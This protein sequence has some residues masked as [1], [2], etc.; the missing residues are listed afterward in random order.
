MIQKHAANPSLGHSVEIER[1]CSVVEFWSKSGAVTRNRSW[2][3]KQQI[4]GGPRSE[5][6]NVHNLSDYS[7]SSDAESL[8]KKLFFCRDVLDGWQSA[9]TKR[10]LRTSGLHVLLSV[11]IVRM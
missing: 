2:S 1:H 6:P 10:V 4:R 8:G 9:R 3:R 7:Y 5:T 11:S